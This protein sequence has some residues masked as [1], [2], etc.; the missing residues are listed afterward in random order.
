MKRCFIDSNILIYAF[1]CDE[2]KSQKAQSIITDHHI[3][4][5]TQVVNEFCNVL[6][7]RSLMGVDR[8]KLLTQEFYNSF[9][10]VIVNKL[11]ITTALTVKQKYGYSYWDSVMIASA[12]NTN[13]PI[14]YSEDMHHS[15]II[16][17]KLTIINPFI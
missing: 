14:I 5:S 1:S 6:L 8:L 12:L 15:H 11:T 4:I 17:N 2:L 10:V 16:D 3:V 7:K 9:D 13:T